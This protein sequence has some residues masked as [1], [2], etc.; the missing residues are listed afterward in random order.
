[1]EMLHLFAPAAVVDATLDLSVHFVRLLAAGIPNQSS[2]RN[3]G[4]MNSLSPTNNFDARLVIGPMQICGLL[5]AALFGCLGCQ[6]YLYFAR[7][8]DDHLALKATV[9]AV[10]LLQLGHF[11]CVMSTLWTMTVSSY[12]DPS[13]LEVAPLAIDLAAPLCGFTVFIVQSFYVFRLW[14]FTG[15]LLLPIICE[16]LS[17]GAQA[18]TLIL[19]ARAVS[20][21]D[22]ATFGDTQFLLIAL[23][24]IVRAACDVVTTAGTAW[25][26]R[27]KR[28]SDIKDTATIID[29]LIYWTIET[30]LITSVMAIT[31]ATWFLV[32]RQNY[33][34]SAV[35]VVWPNVVGNSLLASLNRR[36]LLRET[37]RVTRS[38]ARSRGGK[39]NT[40]VFGAG[41][42]QSQVDPPE[43]FKNLN[44]ENFQEAKGS[45]DQG[46]GQV[47]E[48]VE[49]HVRV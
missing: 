48:P 34:W 12:G 11:I 24:F 30:G 5:N 4:T 21:T 31:L 49:V 39:L 42:T 47:S 19:T 16:A 6:S 23:V 10:T 27:N 13:Q 46:Y 44:V 9:S 20:M 15:S 26:L 36:L 8:M 29:R 3:T 41:A 1:M 17:V 32:V 25:S 37:P 28:G 35:W 18:L 7:F 38:D 2:F 33:V 40:T 45:T 43:N 22:L 14:K